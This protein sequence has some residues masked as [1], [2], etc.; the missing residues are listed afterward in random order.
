MIRDEI[1]VVPDLIKGSGGI[2]D[3]VVDGRMIYSKDK[4]GRFPDPFEVI[5]Q[6]KPVP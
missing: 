1:G 2:F 4:T 5:N 3:V 6:L